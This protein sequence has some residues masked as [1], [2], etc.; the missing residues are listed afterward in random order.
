LEGEIEGLRRNTIALDATPD[1]VLQEL[2]RVM[3]R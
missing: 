1:L 3:S 2:D